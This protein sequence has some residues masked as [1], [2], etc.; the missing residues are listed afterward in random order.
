M[1][2]VEASYPSISRK[3]VG[4]AVLEENDS[5]VISSFR[6]E[7]DE[8]CVITQKNPVLKILLAH[9]IITLC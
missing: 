8:N 1:Q 4:G 5:C 3:K 9:C 2:I 6:C 7:V